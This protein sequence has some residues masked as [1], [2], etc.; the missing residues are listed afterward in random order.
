MRGRG[1]DEVAPGEGRLPGGEPVHAEEVRRSLHV[2]TPRL[3]RTGLAAE[4]RLHC[5]AVE[6]DARSTF[7]PAG[8]EILGGR[9]LVLA[10]AGIERGHLA[11]RARGHVIRGRRG[12][13]L[14]R[15]AR[16]LT[17]LGDGDADDGEAPL[18]VDHGGDPELADQTV[19]PFR[20]DDGSGRCGVLVQGLTVK[21]APAPVGSLHP[22]GDRD[23]GVQQIWSRSWRQVHEGPIAGRRAPGT[24]PRVA[25]LRGVARWSC[26]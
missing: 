6:P 25:I 13:E 3:E 23:V 15:P 12:V 22:G 26:R 10:L 2:E 17:P 14:E 16:E 18:A 7:V 5:L 24:T 20:L 1:A 19:A 8:E 9:H 4:H 21:L 11:S